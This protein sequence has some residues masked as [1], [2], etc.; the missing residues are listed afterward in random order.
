MIAISLR[1][2][3]EAAAVRAQSIS[4]RAA[5]AYENRSIPAEKLGTL[6]ALRSP[7]GEFGIK[8]QESD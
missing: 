2:K 7:L 4:A 3:Q 5:A 8:L 1:M 6:R